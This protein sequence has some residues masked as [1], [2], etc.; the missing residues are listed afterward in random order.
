[1]N[2]QSSP[3]LKG[4]IKEPSIHHFGD[5]LIDRAR[6]LG[7]CFCLGLDPHLSLIPSAFRVPNMT[8][9]LSLATK[10]FEDFFQLCLNKRLIALLL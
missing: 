1:M 8:S 2:K 5:F 7:H 6:S 4:T 9:E 3:A 10:S